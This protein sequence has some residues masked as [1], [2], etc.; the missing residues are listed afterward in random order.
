MRIMITLFLLL[1]GINVAFGATTPK[2]AANPEN[3]FSPSND[4]QRCVMNCDDQF[5]SCISGCYTKKPRDNVS[6]SKRENRCARHDCSTVERQCLIN[7]RKTSGRN[8]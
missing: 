3:L 4:Y 5:K 8:P 7:C 2:D 6:R 1:F